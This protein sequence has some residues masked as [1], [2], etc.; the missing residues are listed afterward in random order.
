MNRKETEKELILVRARARKLQV[1]AEL[2]KHN[3]M[4]GAKAMVKEYQG[5][6]KYIDLLESNLKHHYNNTLPC[7]IHTKPYT[8]SP[9]LIPSLISMLNNRV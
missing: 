8:E 1:W 6:V 9:N 5:L 4:P 3:R 2:Y 7:K